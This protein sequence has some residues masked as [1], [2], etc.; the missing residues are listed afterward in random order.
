MGMSKCFTSPKLATCMNEHDIEGRFWILDV[1]GVVFQTF[2][3]LIHIGDSVLCIFLDFTLTA[4][5]SY[6]RYVCIRTC[7][8]CLDMNHR[9]ENMQTYADSEVRSPIEHWLSIGWFLEAQTSVDHL[10]VKTWLLGAW[11]SGTSA[12]KLND[13]AIFQPFQLQH[14]AGQSLKPSVFG[15][16]S[17]IDPYRTHLEAVLHRDYLADEV[18]LARGKGKRSTPIQRPLLCYIHSKTVRQL[19]WPPSTAR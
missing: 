2:D 5:D 13:S 4:P 6:A 16:N 15:R 7:Q 8:Y 11:R 17:G 1:L 9:E 3:V 18:N 12:F 19:L 10:S 14:L